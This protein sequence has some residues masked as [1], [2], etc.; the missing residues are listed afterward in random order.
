MLYESAFASETLS[1][2]CIYIKIVKYKDKEILEHIHLQVRN[3]R[4]SDTYRRNHDASQN[5]IFGSAHFWIHQQQRYITF[6]YTS[7]GKAVCLILSIHIRDEPCLF[8]HIFLTHQKSHFHEIWILGPFWLNFKHHKARLLET[9]Y[10]TSKQ[11]IM[12]Q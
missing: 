6:I 5:E 8:V 2:D 11:N 12:H 7:E 10:F 1:C 4:W 9:T 3:N